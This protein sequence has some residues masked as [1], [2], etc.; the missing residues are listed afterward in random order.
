MQDDFVHNPD[1]ALARAS[2]D[3]VRLLV[4]CL[5]PLTDLWLEH[6]PL[7]HGPCISAL[8]SF[9]SLPSVSRSL[10]RYVIIHILQLYKYCI[11]RR[12]I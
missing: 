11:C 4:P 9:M 7:P 12:L 8:P 2:A 1:G 3:C 5:F 6:L 10:T